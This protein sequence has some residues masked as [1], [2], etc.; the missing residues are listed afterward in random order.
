MEGGGGQFEV[1]LEQLTTG[2]WNILYFV[3]TSICKE[4]H[5]YGHHII[6][7]A[8]LNFVAR[9]YDPMS[10]DI[11]VIMDKIQRGLFDYVVTHITEYL[12]PYFVLF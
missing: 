9:H 8:K 11:R 2:P 5:P 1:L 10:L 7:W 3:S 4:P 12:G 6:K